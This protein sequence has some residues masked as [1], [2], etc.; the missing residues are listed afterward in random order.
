MPTTFEQSDGP[1]DS[2][3]PPSQNLKRKCIDYHTCALLDVTS[4]L[5]KSRR[6]HDAFYTQPH[7]SYL[8]LNA[9]PTTSIPNP[10]PSSTF[11]TYM[12]VS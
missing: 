12:Y 4:R 2:Q 9:L 1:G 8:R 11:L 6:P 7:S 3:Q 10:I 5:Y